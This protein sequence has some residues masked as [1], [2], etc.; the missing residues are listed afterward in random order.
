[1]RTYLEDRE[2]TAWLLLDRSPSMG[3]GP[4]ERSKEMVLIE[5]ATTLARLL[6]R[7]GNRV[8]AILYNNAIERTIAPLGGRNQ[9][10]RL[11]S[12]L[13]R[14][15]VPTGTTTDLSVLLTAALGTIRRR[16]LVI[17][18]SDF[19]SEPGWERPLSLL[20]QRHELVAIRLLD[21]RELELPDAGVIVVEDAETGELLSVDTS[22]PEFRRRFHA[23]D[24]GPPGGRAGRRPAS[25]R[26]PPRRVDGGRP[27]AGARADRR[28]PAE[29]EALMSFIWPQMLVL[30]VVAPLAGRGLRRAGSAP[31]A[32]GRRAG[33]AGL[34]AHGRGPT[35]PP[36]PAPAVRPVPGRA[37]PA[38]GG[39]R[40]PGD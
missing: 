39:L 26:R 18:V 31:G 12:H 36:P 33:G 40:P 11:A 32:A 16:S 28:A 2:L 37:R 8:G 24:R 5:L 10:L 23:V 25:R 9:V 35:V 4:T 30:L 3:F 22:D 21:R 14:P 20:S 19:I 6:T 7:S 27:G 29:A 13:L 17:L 1:M 38:P 15:A 34:R